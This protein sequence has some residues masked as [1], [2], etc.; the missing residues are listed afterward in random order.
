M[1]LDVTCFHFRFTLK[2]HTKLIHLIIDNH[3]SINQN[4]AGHSMS[5]ST[6]EELQK[7]LNDEE[8][9]RMS[10]L[11][12]TAACTYIYKQENNWRI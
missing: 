7:L 10:P 11:V 8:F 3:L 2:T 6:L 12:N 4:M 1:L 9:C 5:D